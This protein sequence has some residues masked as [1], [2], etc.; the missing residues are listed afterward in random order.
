MNPE[1]SL[2][3]S[4]RSTLFMLLFLASGMVVPLH[5]QLAEQNECSELVKKDIAK[6]KEQKPAVYSTIRDY[7]FEWSRSRQSC[8]MII[9]YNVHQPGKPTQVQISAVN[10]VT[11][12]PMEGY[13][14]IFLIPATNEEEIENAVNFLVE[15][16]SH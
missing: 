2:R 12:Q 4:L 3:R 8:V 6:T 9:Q 1:Q 16:Y 10:A 7:T 5:G 13:K 14:N 11:V 15:R